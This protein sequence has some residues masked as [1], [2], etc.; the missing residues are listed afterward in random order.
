[1]RADDEPV[2]SFAP[3]YFAFTVHQWDEQGGCYMRTVTVLAALAVAGCAHEDVAET[4]TVT[5]IV[6][7]DKIVYQC[8]PEPGGGCNSLKSE[9]ECR[10]HLRCD[11]TRH[12]AGYCHRIY[13]RDN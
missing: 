1:M 4:K 12:G 5:K 3:A 10:A 11:W 9:A 7:R 8:R 6:Y 2:P 13:C